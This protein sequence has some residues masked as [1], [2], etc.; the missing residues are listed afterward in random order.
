MR[1]VALVVALLLIG[2]TAFAGELSIGDELKKLP[3]M[4]Q[5]IGFS[6]VNSNIEYLSTIEV[7][8]FKGVSLEAGYTSQN[9]VIGVASYQ[10]LKLKDL[11]VTI[12]ILDL[13][14]FQPGVFVGYGHINTEEV[15]QSELTYGFSLTLLDVKF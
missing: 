11:G 8:N 14:Y 4:K 13:V 3:A 2:S 7:A 6:L 5:G 1:I 15:D 10:I 12:P 9:K